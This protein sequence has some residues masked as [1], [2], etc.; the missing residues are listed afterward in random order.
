MSAFTKIGSGQRSDVYQAMTDTT[1]IDAL[2][3][4]SYR[5]CIWQLIAAI[6]IA[7][8]GFYDGLL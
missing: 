5:F 2:S 8:D 7:T 6:E 1:G 4:L 3:G